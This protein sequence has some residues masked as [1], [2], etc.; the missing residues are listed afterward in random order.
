MAEFINTI[1][2]LGDDAV[3]D[4]IIQRTITEFKDN[5]LTMVGVRAFRDCTQLTSVDLPVVTSLVEE[6]FQGC[7]S[8]KKITMPL[9][10]NVSR[11]SF[12]LC[13]NLTEISFPEVTVMGGAVFYEC[14]ALKSVDMPKLT[15][16]TGSFPFYGCGLLTSVNFPMLENTNGEFLASCRNIEM[17]DFPRLTRVGKAEYNLCTKLKALIL[18][19]E[20]ACPL[21]NINALNETLISKGTGYI[22][23]PAALV[24]SYK[25]ATNWSTFA[26][27]FRAIEDYTVDGTVMGEFVRCSGI[28]LDKTALTFDNF[29]NQKLTATL[30]TPSP[31]DDDIVTWTSADTS[32]ARVDDGVVTPIKNGTTTITATCNGY[33]ATCEVVVNANMEDAL[34]RLAEPTTFNGTSDYI[35]TGIKLFETA[36]SFTIICVAEF[37][38]L[39]NNRCLFHCM[40]EAAPYPG[41]SVDGNSGIR[42]CYTGSGSLTTSISDKTAVATLAIRYVNGVMDAIR[43]RNTSGNIVTHTVTGA[44]IYTKVTQNL[45]IGAFQEISGTKGR[46]FAGTIDRFEVYG[47]ALPDE[48]IEALI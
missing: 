31:F 42:I 2:A 48:T 44:S 16:V 15:R 38:A 27:Q 37:S 43:Y 46:F 34:Y 14:G 29:A 9:L 8:L 40:N 32:I 39:A 24:E 26:D 19:N 30:S 12:G 1:D 36:K 21:D 6:A 3:I 11:G 13:G 47:A 33:S 25:V 22:Y 17:L 7:T 5:A 18:R 20:T 35:D 10:T 28:T 45:L 23:V 4:S 41:I